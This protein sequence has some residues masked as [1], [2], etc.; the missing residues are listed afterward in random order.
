MLSSIVA[1]PYH[2]FPLSR[3]KNGYYAAEG[4]FPYQVYLLLLN[5]SGDYNECGGSIIGNEWVLTAA[6]CTRNLKSVTVKYGTIHKY[7]EQFSHEVQAEN[8][9]SHP[10]FDDKLGENDIALIRTPHVE[11]SERVQKVALADRDKEYANAWAI[12]S[13]FGRTENGG[14]DMLKYVEVQILPQAKCFEEL[15]RKTS[16]ILCVSIVD[17]KSTYFGDS[18]GPLVSI[19]DHKLV[20]VCSFGMEK[21]NALNKVGSHRDWIRDTAGID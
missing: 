3:I 15:Q 11:F 1:N 19:D 6:H 16:T 13:G 4:Q 10:Q 9:F 14:N 12:A 8:V 5:T 18:G 7:A 2:S 20:A 21:V 17:G